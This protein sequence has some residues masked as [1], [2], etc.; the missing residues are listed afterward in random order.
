MT[1]F[2]LID[3]CGHCGGSWFVM[4]CHRHPAGIA[5]VNEA[6]MP[7]QLDFEY[8]CPNDV[9]DR[10]LIDFMQGA[11]ATHAA[12]GV[13]K[14]FHRDCIEWVQARGGYVVTW[15]RNPLTVAG[16]KC[17]RYTHKGEQITGHPARTEKERIEAHFAYYG[18]FFKRMLE[19]SLK[20]GRRIVRIEDLNRSVGSD[21]QAF[22]ESM[23]YITGVAWPPEMLEIGAAHPPGDEAPY[24][25]GTHAHDGSWP[26][27]DWSTLRGKHKWAWDPAPYWHW[28]SWEPWQRDCF[29]EH[30]GQSMHALGYDRPPAQA[31]TFAWDVD[32][33][34]SSPI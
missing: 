3:Q 28:K 24:G 4:M 19:R 11:Q 12:C 17:G 26:F 25:A 2:F 14:G 8:P 6:H 29:V 18:R 27:E 1:K 16:W 13:L 9:Y 10:H 15:L 33:D 30:C 7:N 5:V 20:N 32:P 21:G 23:E 31:P 22:T 34:W